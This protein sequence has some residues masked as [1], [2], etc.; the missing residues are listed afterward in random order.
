MEA[1]SPLWIWYL[2]AAACLLAGVG[3]V[4]LYAWLPVDGATGDLASMQRHGFQIQWVLQ[5]R[6]PGL[7]PGDVVLRAGGHTLDEWLS[8]AERG[9]TWDS[10]ATV[11]YEVQR[12]AHT[13]HLPLRLAPIPLRAVLRRWSLQ[14]AVALAFFLIGMFVTWKRPQDLAARLLMLF[15][16]AMA[17]QFVGDAYNLQVATLP[18]R[19]PF[20]LHVTYEHAMFGITIATIAWFALIFPS[21]HPAIQRAPVLLPAM[22]YAAFPLAIGL[23]MALSPDWTTALRDGSRAAWGVTLAE[24]ALTFAASIRSS[25]V[26]RS[27]VARAQIRWI[28]WCGAVG[29]AILVPGYVLPLIL[30][31]DPV[32][33][34]PATMMVTALIPL[35]LAVAIL[36]YRLFDIYVVIHRT[37]VYATLTTLLVGLYLLVVWVLSSLANLLWQGENDN[38][39]VFAATLTIALAFDPLRR[40]VQRLIDLALYRSRPDYQRLVSDVSERLATR[41]VLQDLAH[42]L[43]QEI[44]RRLQ[45]TSASLAVLDLEEAFFV[46]AGDGHHGTSLPAQHPLPAFLQHS[47]Q[48]LLRLQPPPELPD[49]ALAFLERQGVEMSIPLIVGTKTVGLYNLGSKQSGQAYLGDEIRLLHLLGR[50]AAVALENSRLYEQARQEIAERRRAEEQ[51]K[52]S[53]VEKE[54]LLKEIHHRV[55]NNLQVISSLL[56]LQSKGSDDTR[57]LG[58]LSESR[59]RLRSMALIHEQLYQTEHLDR[60]LAPRYLRSLTSYLFRSHSD[61]SG[62]VKLRLDIDSIWLTIDVAVPCGLLVNELLSNAL[63]HAF[64]PGTPGETLVALKSSGK[65]DLRLVVADNGIGLPPDLDLQDPSGLGL[66]LVDMLVQQLDGI[67]HLDS[68][69]GTHFEVI[70]PAPSKE[71]G[72][73]P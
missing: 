64:A 5:A 32:I 52:A 45:I 40:R 27:P 44:P 34:H 58:L 38:P 46:P 21:A 16:V 25:Q 68:Q 15:C 41:L 39:I 8:G 11:T 37:L 12:Q 28:V 42:L 60:V 10:G 2:L 24:L 3:L 14:L 71:G 49:A 6:D 30:S 51:L 18:W 55:K 36:H 59:H 63:K 72:Q 69:Q 20:W 66:Q 61:H 26:A 23:T 9:S 67:V 4:G 65:G 17:M 29:C 7:L 48:S 33:P 57:V 73:F 70:F 22:L 1:K 56:Y 43:T 62:L 47:G 19:W 31:G 53:L 54:I 35:T 50:Q 13:L